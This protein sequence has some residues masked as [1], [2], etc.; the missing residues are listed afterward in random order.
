MLR[1]LLLVLVALLAP[2]A[3]I[4]APADG[5]SG[6]VVAVAADA[7]EVDAAKLRAAVGQELGTEALSPGD[8][9]AAGA[10]GRIDVSVDRASHSLVV[11]YRGGAEPIERRVELPGTA[12]A[13]AREAVLLAGNLARDEASE[14]VVALRKSRAAAAPAPE[15]APAAQPSPEDAA[16]IATDERLRQVLAGHARSDRALRLAVSW[17]ALGL[18]TA[19]V[20]AGVYVDTRP[21]GTA[22]ALLV[23]TGLPF[24][25][26]GGVLLVRPSL[27]PSPFEEMSAHYQARLAAGQPM[28]W[29][30]D[31]VEQAW[32]R[33]ADGEHRAR[34]G[35]AAACVGL[36]LAWG[37]INAF[38]Y[39]TFPNSDKTEL[40]AVGIGVA[41]LGIVAGVVLL[42]T[43][44]SIESRLHRYERGLGHPVELTD[45]GLRLLPVRGGLA[46]GVGA[47]F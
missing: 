40:V 5:G 47:R 31:E 17:A 26:G 30:R 13:I 10:R 42:T 45:V 1:I 37:A 20:A 38:V 24:A 28:P 43:E 14:L 3:A 35:A 2:R 18:G 11:S 34:L 25:I 46:A 32:R 4:A 7:G 8:P 36:G 27:F 22:G 21:G 23:S 39:P 12:E 29:L 44:G 16:E 9:R 33:R 41:S 15:R 19:A 6:V